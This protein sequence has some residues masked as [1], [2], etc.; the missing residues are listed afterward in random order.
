MDAWEQAFHIN[1]TAPLRLLHAL[2]ESRNARAGQPPL[3]LFFAGGGTNSAPLNY[4]AYTV[5]K[6]ALIKAVELLDA[7]MQDMRFSIV[8][9]GWVK[10]KIHQETLKAGD[11]KSA[12]A[13]GRTRSR[14]QTDNFTSMESI[15]DC[16]N[17]LIQQP[18][19]VIGG[20]NF[21]VAHDFKNIQNLAAMLRSNQD[22]YK[23]RRAGNDRLI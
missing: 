10:T 13:A 7:E 20:R 3:A 22:M 8:G 4:S 21:S 6:I 19:E 14:L 9:P 11:S 12:G 17:W 2:L 16:C 18:K 23:L 15:I 5:S 1:L